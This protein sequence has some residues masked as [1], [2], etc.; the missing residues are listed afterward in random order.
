MRQEEDKR[1]AQEKARLISKPK[2][3]PSSTSELC[4]G[5]N[6]CPK[7][8]EIPQVVS[9]VRSIVHSLA[10]FIRETLTMDIEGVFQR[11]ASNACHC[12]IVR[13]RAARTRQRSTQSLS[14]YAA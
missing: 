8:S 3:G 9:H 2:F 11:K 13:K 10:R 12:E 5:Q 1:A 4:R 6:C 14:E 7:S